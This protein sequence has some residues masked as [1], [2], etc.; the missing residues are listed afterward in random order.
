MSDDDEEAHS[1]F[2]PASGPV[3]ERIASALEYIATQLGQINRKLDY[4]TG[5]YEDEDEEDED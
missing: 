2:K 1:S 5:V 3:D 4:L